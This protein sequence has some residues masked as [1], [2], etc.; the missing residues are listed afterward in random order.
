MRKQS[1]DTPCPFGS[2]F[3]PKCGSW[4]ETETLK[5]TSQY[6]NHVGHENRMGYN[7]ILEAVVSTA[8][9]DVIP[10]AR[11]LSASSH[12]PRTSLS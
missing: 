3:T 11:R 12:S 10:C 4:L 1:T 5:Y 2:S 9:L 7:A 8:C 6:P